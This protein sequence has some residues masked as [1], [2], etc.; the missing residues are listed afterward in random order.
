[1]VISLTPDI[2]QAL[3]E[4]ASQQ[5]T[6]IEFLA[7]KTLRERL[8]LAAS[9]PVAQQQPAPK[10]LANFLTGYVGVLDSG[11]LS[12]ESGQHSKTNGSGFEIY[13]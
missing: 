5:G 3:R 9:P 10:T 8:F 4:L 6:T 2:E 1:M 7:L 11:E 12:K 13:S